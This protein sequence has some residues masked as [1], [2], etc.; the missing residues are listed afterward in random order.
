MAA[1]RDRDLCD[2][3]NHC[4]LPGE[5]CWRLL[6]ASSVT[7]PATAQNNLIT[8]TAVDP[9]GN[10]YLCNALTGE[11]VESLNLGPGGFAPFPF[12]LPR[13]PIQVFVLGRRGLPCLPLTGLE[14]STARMPHRFK[15]PEKHPPASE[16]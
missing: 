2:L 6:P 8:A 12:L 9:E 1:G 15:W 5:F 16:V 13:F 14:T 7:Y 10:I 4:A 11:L 3:R